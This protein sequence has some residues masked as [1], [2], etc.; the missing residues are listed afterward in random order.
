MAP[1]QLVLIT[2]Q[3]E[4]GPPTAS[5]GISYHERSHPGSKMSSTSSNKLLKAKPMG[6]PVE[7]ERCC[8]NS[9]SFASAKQVQPIVIKDLPQ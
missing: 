7:V 5:A 9:I 1:R 4:L 3:Q 2:C 8:L 6:R